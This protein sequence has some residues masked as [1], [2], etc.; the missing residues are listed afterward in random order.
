MADTITLPGT[1]SVVG[2][3]EVTIGAVLQHLQRIKLYD[4]T[5]G[6]T[7]AIAGSAANGLDVDVTRVQGIVDIQ[8]VQDTPVTGS[9]TTSTSTVTDTN[10]SNF[11]LATIAIFGTYAGITAVFEASPDGTNWFSIQGQR[12]DSGIIEAGFTTL[13]NTARA[14][15]VFIGAWTQ[16]RVRATARTSGTASV[17]IIKQ[18]MPTEPAP[19]AMLQP[20]IGGGCTPY[21]FLSTAAV[22]AASIKASP[23]QVYG[24]AFTNTSATI[25]YVRLYNQTT[26]PATGDTANIRFRIAIPGNTAGAGLVLPIT[27]GM[28]FPTGIGIRVSAAV[29]DN[30]ATALAANAVQGNVFYK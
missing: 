23:G 20:A 24:L 5:D 3:D 7:E 17:V 18:T 12:T 28:E 25:A 4:G 26:S 30:D 29:A 14:W 27:Q 21:T 9:I 8:G 11:N 22:Q 13:T 1:G 10:A 19:S 2:T 15:D 6:G 16:I